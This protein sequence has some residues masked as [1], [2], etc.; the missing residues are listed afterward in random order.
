MIYFIYSPELSRLKIGYTNDVKKRFSQIK[1]HS[2]SKL[3]LLGHS[4]GDFEKERF[5]H[6]KFKENRNHLEWFKLDLAMLKQLNEYITNK[7]I[8]Y[9]AAYCILKSI[10]NYGFVNM[11]YCNG[12]TKD[13]NIEPWLNWVKIT[14]LN[15]DFKE[16][17]NSMICHLNM[18]NLKQT[19]VYYTHDFNCGILNFKDHILCLA[20]NVCWYKENIGYIED[21]ILSEDYFFQDTYIDKDGL[22][23]KIRELSGLKYA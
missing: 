5:L 3:V 15:C 6:E 16:L 7:N 2:P 10:L 4:E 1:T 14:N 8:D 23:K 21:F 9:F 19:D 22:I 13:N 17:Y 20:K 18:M 12:D 11:P